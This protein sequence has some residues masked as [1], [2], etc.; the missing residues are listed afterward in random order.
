M[1][2][3]VDNYYE[4]L[5]ST[6]IKELLEACKADQSPDMDKWGRLLTNEQ[7]SWEGPGGETSLAYTPL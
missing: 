7:V 2:Q 4:R 3:F 1:V 5:N 6:S